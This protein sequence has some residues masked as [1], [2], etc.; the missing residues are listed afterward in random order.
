[1]RKKLFTFLLA[2]VTSVGMMWA[3]NPSGSCGTNLSWEFNPATGTLTITGSG[4][5]TDWASATSRPWHSYQ[6]DI[7]SLSLPEGLTFIGRSAFQ[8]CQ[9]T[10]VELP[11]SLLEIGRAAFCACG[12]TSVTIPD[13][14]QTIGQSAFASCQNL[15]TITIGSGVTSIGYFAFSN[16]MI[17]PWPSRKLESVTCYATN[18]PTCGFDESFSE[19]WDKEQVPLYVPAESV[20]AYSAAE[21]WNGF[22]VQAISG[23]STPEEPE[24]V[25]YTELP[26]TMEATSAGTIVIHQ[27]K[28]QM[29]YSINGGSKQTV[30]ST[31]DVEINVAAGDKV[32]FYGNGTSITNYAVYY[33]RTRIAGGTADCIVYGNIMSLI[34]EYD[35]ATNTTLTS[36]HESAFSQI[37]SGN[38]KLTDASHLILPA[39]TLSVG[40][41]SSLFYGCTALTKVPVLPATTMEMSCYNNMFGDCTSL[42]D[43]PV[44]PATTLAESCYLGMFSGCHALTTAPELP[45]TTLVEECYKDMFMY[46]SHLNSITCLATDISAYKCTS[47]W[48]FLVASTGTFYKAEGMND[49]ELNSVNGIPEGWTVSNAGGGS[50]EPEEPS[51]TTVTWDLSDM[52]SMGTQGGYFKAKGIT[53]M[54]YGVDNGMTGDGIYGGA[55]FGGPFVFTTSLG[56]FTK[57]EVTNS[58]LYEQPAFS[59]DDWTLD[60]TNAVWEGTPAAL[61]SLVSNFGGIT[62]IKFTIDPNTSTPANS[63]GDGLTWAVNNGELTISYDGVGTGSMD[64]YDDP[65]SMPWFGQNIT[66]VVLPEGLISIGQNA[67]AFINTFSQI[68]L[69]STLQYILMNAF[70]G[71]GLTSVTIPE[72]VKG[73]GVSAFISSSSLATV[74]FEP[75]TPP[76]VGGNA[77]EYCHNDLIIYYPCESRALYYKD[78]QADI[79]YYRDK[80]NYCPA[81]QSNLHV[82][83]LEPPTSWSGKSTTYLGVADMPGFEETDSLLATQWEAPTDCNS[84]LIYHVVEQYGDERM[85]YHYFYAGDF[86]E[87]QDGWYPLGTVYSN[88]NSGIKTFY[89]I[90]GGGSTPAVDPAVQNVID[91]I[92]AIPNPVVY[93][94]ECF[95]ALNAVFDAYVALSEEQR[96]QVTNYDD[97]QAAEARYYMLADVNYVIEKINEIGDVEFTSACKHK[98]DYARS[99]YCNLTLEAKGYVTNYNTL[100]AAEA[101]YAALI[102]VSS[103]VVWDEAILETIDV[104]E[105]NV[106]TFTNG[107]I[108][109]KAVDGHAYYVDDEQHFLFDGSN[110]EKSFVFSCTSANMLCIEIEVSEKHQHNELSCAWQETATGYRWVGEA[111]SVDLASTIFKVTGIRFSLGE[112]FPEPT[113][114]PAQDGDKLPGAFSVSGEKVVYFSKGNLQYLGNIDRWHFAE[115]QWTIIGNSQADNNRDL[116]SWGTGDNPDSEDYST[117]TEWGNNIEGNWRTLTVDEWTYLFKTRTDASSKYGTSTVAGVVGLILLPD[118]YDGTAINT[119]RTAWDNNV[120]SSSAWAAYEA[121]G[122][123]FL[124]AA[125]LSD[126]YGVY[127]V[128]E[129]GFY[130]SSTMDELSHYAISIFYGFNDWEGYWFNDVDAQFQPQQRH[131]VRLVSETAPTP[132]GPTYLDADFAIDFRTDPYTKVGGGDLPAGVEVA[133]EFHDGQHGYRLP[134]VT[135]PVTAGNYLVKMGTCKHSNQDGAVKNEDGT[136]TYATLATN[137][138][139]CYDANPATN[140]VAAI[141]TI[142]NDQVIKVY[143]AEYTP[144]FSIAKMPEIPVF[145]DF[146]INFQSDP[147]NVISGAKPEGTVIIGTY[148]DNLHGYQ[149]VEA[150]VPVEAGNYRL[151]VGACQYGTPGNVMSETNAELASFNSNL[152]EGNCYHNNTAA[153]IVSTIFAVDMD[154]TITI[155]G[156]AYMPYMKLEKLQDNTYYINF[157]NAEGAIGTVPGEIAVAAGESWTIPANLT[158]YKEGYT[159]AGWSDGVNTYA[160]GDEFFPNEHGTLQAVYTPNSVS[161]ADASTINVKWYFG[162]SNGAPSVTWNGA[163]GYLLAKGEVDGELIDLKLDIDATSGKFQNAGRGDKWAQVN[164]GTVFTF[165]SKEGAVVNVETYSGNETYV[166]GDGTLTCNTN[167]Y[168]SYLEIVYPTP[169]AVET[170]DNDDAETINTKLEANDGQT[171]DEWTIVR[172][173]YRNTYY[174][175]LCLPFDMDAAQIAASS[176]A[177]AE[178]KEFTGAEVVGDELLIDLAPVDEIEAGKPYFIKYSNADALTQLDFTNVTID[179]TAPQGV[180][181]NGVTLQGTFVPFQMEAQSNLNYEG[182][183][184]FLGQNNQ[185]F[186]PGVTNSIKPFRAYF[187]V[188][189]TPSNQNGAP[190]RYGMPARFNEEQVA[191]SIGNVQGDKVQSTKV[192]RDGQLIIIRNGVE[193]NANG[194]MVK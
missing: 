100:L 182:G 169:T 153:N 25:N 189:T 168:Y 139:V 177:G 21:D 129:Q 31:D 26:L 54:A 140:Y 43:A 22:D 9:M 19:L 193:Y 194:M 188:D 61:V 183:Y 179:A 112:A 159:F 107:S 59:G 47:N 114:T 187:Y 36:D 46:C 82:T 147:Y 77:F 86:V 23:G 154:Q 83:E 155:N 89:T 93:N 160:P 144:Y 78:L 166:L 37:F 14:V 141:I 44:L 180:T 111:T 10:S 11:N 57:I 175:T 149:N 116:F 186:W 145:T 99:E 29:H 109:L 3:Q 126:A 52:A 92:N 106:T 131:S 132:A 96:D 98:I 110:S 121:A 148:H 33:D 181:F 133:G 146:E 51:E 172:P 162:E 142:P 4:A 48:V 150:V 102:P 16:L 185:L 75:T 30:Y 70:S 91:L 103:T 176:I 190:K 58:Y 143:G 79:A 66:S 7:T 90:S 17:E 152:G 42:V 18:P 151:T 50:S 38:T 94:Q 34:D 163:A 120:I 158:L 62:Q 27:A 117:Y 2:L 136:V 170:G 128:G 108:S 68:T 105:W 15:S 118:N 76:R 13:N 28:Y 67:F 125:G 178:I 73:I 80:M 64:N 88:A 97:Y 69:P 35:F 5:M 135:I 156:G 40:C 55:Y 161:I 104:D 81:P 124:P 122:A 167:D 6:S 130:W 101:A 164:N 60:G 74:T 137:T 32:A 39:T 119:E 138:G 85:Y 127:G 115:N 123:V 45:A 20:A 113:P 71:C 8:E 165:P 95:N 84:V 1:M 56:K 63:C 171:V 72:N 65:L 53:L 191:T 134:V 87:S 192:L 173:V 41:Y 174:N 12:L 157:E 24:E 184:L 49:W